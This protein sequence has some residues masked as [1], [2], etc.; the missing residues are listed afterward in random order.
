MVCRSQATTTADRASIYTTSATG[1]RYSE[2]RFEVL[3]QEREEWRGLG[4][5]ACAR[6]GRDGADERTEDGIGAG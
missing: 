6:G 5:S 2:W 4:V 3:D 1:R